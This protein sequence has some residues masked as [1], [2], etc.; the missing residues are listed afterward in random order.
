M[1][2]IILETIKG[3]ANTYGITI[4]T[5]TVASICVGCLVELFKIA[6]F[7]RI[8]SK[9]KSDED[10]LAKVKTVKSTS[11]FAVALVLT[12]T[13]LTCIYKSDLPTIGGFAAQPIWFTAMFLL[14]MLCDI[15]GLKDFLRRVVN[16]V[17]PEKTETKPKKKRVK[18]KKVVNWVKVE[19]ED[20]EE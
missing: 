10:R 20:G 4:L 7:T 1:I 12:A 2:E 19:D 18:M 3:F 5:F 11:A 6:V 16:G 14:Q 9:C 8:E 17:V 13:F 15:K